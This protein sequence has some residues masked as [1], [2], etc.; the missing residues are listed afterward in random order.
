MEYTFRQVLSRPDKEGRCRIILDVTWEGQRQKMPTGVSCLPEHFQ[1]GAK[2]VVNPKDPQ[3]AIY[4]A[5]LA[6]LVDKVEKV[7]LQAAANEEVFVPPVK[8]KRVKSQAPKLTTPT[9]F[10]VA[11]LAE[12]PHQ[13]TSGARRYK[14]VV[15]HLEAFRAEWPITTLTRKEY[16]DYMAHVASLGLVDSTTIKHV[17]FLREC[18]RLAG[19]AVPSWLKMQVR[20]GRSPALQAT[21]LRKLINLPLFEQE[22]LIQERDMFLL[23]TLLML[24]DSDLRQLK[25]HHVTTLDLPGV[26]PTPV[27]SIRQV[28]T[29]DEVR[30]PLPPLAA[31]I[32]AKYDGQLPV[33]VQQ[34]RN[35]YMKLL[36]ERAGLTRDFV[37]VR[38][39]QGEA[40]EEVVPLW[41]VVTTH[42]ARHT[43]ADMI[44]L[45]SGGD[46]NL[47]EKA[48]GHAGVYGHDALE[49]YG[50]ALLKAWK[51]VLG[52]KAENAPK[53]KPIKTQ[54]APK[55][56]GGGM[57]IGLVKRQ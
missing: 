53:S 10:H 33:K 1:P 16:L 50:P 18:F 21:E 30:L 5:K 54:N 19:L 34:H 41:Q 20:Y 56:T 23:Q 13:S 24:R 29:G 4:N 38:Y 26:G 8:P 25:P 15:A 3:A 43:G 12:N 40:T 31:S 11:W 22:I 36:M 17:K 14:Q 42:T 7:Q 37:R 46:T 49:R 51:T 47:K 55:Y 27:L 45:G 48:L 57:S 44:M 35:R 6:A 28:K 52:A 32:W 2:R 9:D 39:V